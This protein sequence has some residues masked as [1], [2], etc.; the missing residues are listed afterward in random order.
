[1]YSALATV[2]FV[3]MILSRQLAMYRNISFHRESVRSTLCGFLKVDFVFP[4]G[5]AI[6][7]LN[8]N[9]QEIYGR[10]ILDFL[11][12]CFDKVAHSRFPRTFY[13]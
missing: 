9:P 1:M 6:F 4:V 12:C 3:Y 7:F 10:I 11:H 8:S 13:S 5:P 2:Q